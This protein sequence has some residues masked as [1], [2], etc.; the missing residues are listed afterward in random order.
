MMQVFEDGATTA[1]LSLDVYIVCHKVTELESTF[2][3][4]SNLHEKANV[5]KYKLHQKA[6]SWNTS[7]LY[8]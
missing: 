2:Q 3:L 5:Q 8:K 1:F 6:I 7:V 4:K